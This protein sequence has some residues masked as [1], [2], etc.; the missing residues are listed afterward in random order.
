MCIVVA[1]LMQYYWTVT[2][3]L[4]HQTQG[5]ENL[6]PIFFCLFH[7]HVLNAWQKAAK[8]VHSR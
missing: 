8:F 2:S 3:G 4:Q 6:G 7:M 1:T 5:T